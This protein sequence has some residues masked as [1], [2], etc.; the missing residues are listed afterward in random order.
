MIN[1][2][3]VSWLTL[4][5]QLFKVLSPFVENNF[6]LCLV[7]YFEQNTLSLSN[8]RHKIPGSELEVRR[9]CRS[10]R[11]RKEGAGGWRL[12]HS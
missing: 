6:F 12:E 8:R 1:L 10:C 11:C 9:V 7:L 5:G 3:F 2:R 4:H